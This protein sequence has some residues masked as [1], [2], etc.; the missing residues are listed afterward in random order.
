M[1]TSFI[2]C[3]EPPAGY[4][5]MCMTD[6]DKLTLTAIKVH[7]MHF[8]ATGKSF[9]SMHNSEIRY[10]YNN[11]FQHLRSS[12]LFACMT[13]M[14]PMHVGKRTPAA[15]AGDTAVGLFGAVNADAKSLLHPVAK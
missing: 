13:C 4:L 8:S 11:M 14:H 7:A 2:I 6:R 5:L 9:T 10:M 3:V 12:V 15:S 1:H